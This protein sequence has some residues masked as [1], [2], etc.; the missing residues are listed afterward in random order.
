VVG[1]RAGVSEEAALETSLAAPQ[2]F[3]VPLPGVPGLYRI[4][5]GST[6]V[7]GQSATVR[8]DQMSIQASISRHLDS[9]SDLYH[10]GVDPSSGAVTLKFHFPAVARER[11]ADALAHIVA[12]TGVVVT[13]DPQP[14]QGALADAAL[15]ALPP[16]LQPVRSPA[17]HHAEQ[18]VRIQCEGESVDMALIEATAAQFHTE[19]GWR[20]DLILPGQT[21]RATSQEVWEPVTAT[22]W[23]EYN[24]ARAVAAEFFDPSSGCYKIG[25]DQASSTLILR[26][27]FPDTA[28]RRYA[29]ELATLAHETGW[30]VALHPEPHQGA[31]QTQARQ[32]LPPELRVIGTPALQHPNRTVVVRCQGATPAELDAAR[33]AFTETTGWG[34]VVQG[35]GPPA[36]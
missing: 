10:R 18:I 6:V 20:L 13:V 31:L 11:Y 7:P 23:L 24:A 2:P 33:A 1:H 15:R 9:A 32:V 21:T 26:F 28:R 35:D 25:A 30:R 14:H 29:E 22:R 5:A 12:E 3:F 17:I 19:T 16:G 8:P 27:H 4:R 36:P 34:L